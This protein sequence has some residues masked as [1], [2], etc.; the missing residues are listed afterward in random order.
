DRRRAARVGRC[1]ETEVVQK[2]EIDRSPPPGCVVFCGK[3]GDQGRR[4]YAVA[5]DPKSNAG[6]LREDSR[7]DRR[8]LREAAKLRISGLGARN[9]RGAVQEAPE[10]TYI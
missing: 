2:K 10:P 7:F 4:R 6:H 1:I 5:L 8:C 9:D 3:G